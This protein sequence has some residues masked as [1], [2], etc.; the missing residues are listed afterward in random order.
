MWLSVT[1]V[2]VESQSSASLDTPSMLALKASLGNPES[3]GWSD[4]D[5]CK[6][7]HVMCFNNRVTDIQ[8]GS[9]N[10]KGTLPPD[11]NNLTFLKKL[12]VMQNQ[13]SGQLPILSGLNALQQ[14]LVNENNFSFISSDFFT[15]LTAL[16]IIYLDYN[17]FLPWQIPES[18]KHASGLQIF[19]AN[20]ANVTGTLPDFLN[21][22]TFPRLEHLHLAFNNLQGPI[23]LSFANSFL[24]SLWLNEQTSTIPDLS[25]LSN[26]N[27]LSLRGNGLSGIVPSSLVN[28]LKLAI[29]NLTDNYLQGP[30][31]KFDTTRV[32]V[33]MKAGSNS[34]CLDEPGVACDPRIDL[35][36]STLEPLAL[37]YPTFLAKAWKG[38]DPGTWIAIG[39]NSQ[40]HITFINYNY[41]GFSG[42]ISPKFAKFPFLEDLLLRNNSLTGTIPDE[43]TT[44]SNLTW[45]DV[46][47]NSLS[48]KEPNFGPNVKVDTEGNPNIGKLFG[49]GGRHSH[50]G[51]PSRRRLDRRENGYRCGGES[52][53]QHAT[54]INGCCNNGPG[55]ATP[56]QAMSGPK[57][58]LLYVTC[59]YSE[60]PD[61]L[62]TMDVDPNS[63]T[64]S[65]IIHRLPVPYVG[66]ELHHSGW[67]S[68][69]SCHGDPSA[70]RRFL[71]LP[72]LIMY[73]IHL[74]GMF[75]DALARLS[76]RLQFAECVKIC[77]IHIFYC[78][79][80]IGS[81]LHT[82]HCLA[83]GDLLVVCLGDKDGNAEGN[84]FHLFDSEFNVKGRWEKPGHS[85]LFEYDFRY[86]PRYKTM[87][88]SSW[89]APLA[90]TKGFN[91]QHE[92]DGLYGR[93]LYVYS[94]PEGEL[95][96]TMD[97]GNTGLIPLEIRFLHDPSK[98]TGY[99]GCALTSNMVRFFKTPDGSWSHEVAISM[100]PL[101]V[102]NWILP[103]MP[104]L[105]RTSIERR[106]SNGA[107]DR[108]FYPELMDKGS[109]MLH[110][111]VD[112]VKGGLAIN[113]NFL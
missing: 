27:Y 102:Q 99:V 76:Y 55:Y 113:P 26:L 96:Q 68:C 10:L 25:G 35:L 2:S 34:F 86:Q 62:G 31:P 89:G 57:E 4:T 24:Q 63:P 71:V 101:K 5:P 58:K 108:Q 17:P 65:K 23:P 1:V 21:R 77:M 52:V 110:I 70:Q 91:P 78:F 8:I 64:Y 111:D 103:E 41:R 100:E 66:D 37:G 98:D 56:L 33:D 11:L 18:L 7:A 67:N 19:S 15:G 107:W 80:Q 45:L 69:S 59:V 73:Q 106:T 38:N 22:D 79:F 30:T 88:S 47:N 105:I 6:W 29:V 83:S 84:G 36:L 48:G 28:H 54:V 46:A 92:S 9:Q 13:L 20:A 95:K 109:H 85:P 49:G 14:F 16:Q 74:Y 60:K 87:I 50:P 90:F 53:I 51:I 72:S 39:C 3:L 81:N 43:L 40:G 93:L 82:S 104:G 75:K 12:E 94:W 42:T 32:E 61:Y 44:L 97:L 112:S